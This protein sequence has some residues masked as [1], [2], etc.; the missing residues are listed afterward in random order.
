MNKDLSLK[1]PKEISCRITQTL[2]MYV[3]ENNNGTLGNLLNG[4]DLDE[5]YLS[6]TNNWVSHAFLQILYKRMITTM[7]ST[8]WP[9]PPVAFNP[10][11]FLIELP[12]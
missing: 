4:L 6:D 8:I 11:E 12:A 3:R 9:W 10:W 7:R 2:L 1:M 5:G